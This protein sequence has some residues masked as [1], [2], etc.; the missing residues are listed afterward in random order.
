MSCCHSIFSRAGVYLNNSNRRPCQNN[1]PEAHSFKWPPKLNAHWTKTIDLMHAN[2]GSHAAHRK[3][4][5]SPSPRSK[6]ISQNT[7]HDPDEPQIEANTTSH[8]LEVWLLLP[9]NAD[10]RLILIYS[11]RLS[12]VRHAVPVYQSLSW[13]S[14]AW[15]GCELRGNKFSFGKIILCAMSF[16]F[17]MIPGF[18]KWVDVDTWIESSIMLLVM[19]SRLAGLLLQHHKIISIVIPTSRIDWWNGSAIEARRGH[20]LITFETFRWNI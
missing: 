10:M 11:S 13:D 6:A 1:L 19:V 4:D 3:K 12:G 17:L 15:F 20:A 14:R 5:L 9:D 8:S 18:L 7:N 16:L 2:K